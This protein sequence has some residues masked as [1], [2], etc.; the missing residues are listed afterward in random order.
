MLT[1]AEAM[2]TTSDEPETVR[3]L[4]ALSARHSE[5]AMTRARLLLAQMA[6]EG[7]G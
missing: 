2:L 7:E 1:G 6:R 5:A 4:L 3:W